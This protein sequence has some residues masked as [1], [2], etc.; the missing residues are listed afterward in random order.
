MLLEL[1]K[2]HLLLKNLIFLLLK[3]ILRFLNLLL[4]CPRAFGLHIY[5]FHTFQRVQCG[6]ILILLFITTTLWRDPLRGGAGGRLRLAWP[7]AKELVPQVVVGVAGDGEA[8]QLPPA[9]HLQHHL[10]PPLLTLH[11]VLRKWGRTKNTNYYY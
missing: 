3:N 11:H 6:W 1:C 9:R 10:Q 5:R 7:V 8:A 4:R 2:F